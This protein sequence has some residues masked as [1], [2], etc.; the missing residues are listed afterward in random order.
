MKEISTTEL[1]ELLEKGQQLNLVD[2][3]EADEVASGMI[4]GA[5][6][7]PLGDVPA[8]MD[9]LDKSKPYILICRSSGRSGRAGEFLD[10][11]GYDV[12][13]MIGGMLAWE[14]PTK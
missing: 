1:Q 8:R 2:V 14:G 7:I 6:H 4:P 9:E 13:N 5:I 3:R 12:T 11:Q 10:E